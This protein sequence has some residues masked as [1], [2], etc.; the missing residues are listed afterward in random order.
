MAPASSFL[1]SGIFCLSDGSRMTNPSYYTEYLST[2][3]LINSDPPINVSIRKYAPHSEALYPDGTIVFLVAK[4]A[5]PGNEDGMLDVVHCTPFQSSWEEFRKSLPS[6][7][8]HTASVIG[9]ISAIS[10]IGPLTTLRPSLQD[11][12]AATPPISPWNLGISDTLFAHRDFPRIQYG[13]PTSRIFFSPLDDKI[14]RKLRDRDRLLSVHNV[15]V[16]AAR[17]PDI[18]TT[19]HASLHDRSRSSL[20]LFAE[21]LRINPRVF[22]LNYDTNMDAEQVSALHTISFC[23][24]RFDPNSDSDFCVYFAL[25]TQGV[26]ALVTDLA[27]F[28]RS[29]GQKLIKWS[30]LGH[31][32]HLGPGNPLHPTLQ[33]LAY[34]WDGVATAHGVLQFSAEPVAVMNIQRVFHQTALICAPLCLIHRYEYLATGIFSDVEQWTLLL[35]FN[36]MELA[37]RELCDDI[38]LFVGTTDHTKRLPF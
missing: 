21:S 11:Q 15:D 7:P 13:P 5:L 12:M 31:P 23:H 35:A 17:I 9:T 16:Q 19:F 32:D 10:D 6:G 1:L 28:I 20:L 25:E 4:A 8:V 2:L 37:A 36:E 34:C 27:L 3:D 14:D 29:V 26:E 38:D 30:V 22:T 18:L 24:P 33:D